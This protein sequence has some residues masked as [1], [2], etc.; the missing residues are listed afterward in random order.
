MRRKMD[1]KIPADDAHNGIVE[2][3]KAAVFDMLIAEHFL[4]TKDYSRA[5]IRV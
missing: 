4:R 2:I 1:T 3:R 5:L